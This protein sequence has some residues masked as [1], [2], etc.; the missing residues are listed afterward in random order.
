M[1]LQAE[2]QE[3]LAPVLK[4][5]KGVRNNKQEREFAAVKH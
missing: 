4:V 2:G 5:G 3:Q 1:G